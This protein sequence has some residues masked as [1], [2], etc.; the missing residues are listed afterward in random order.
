[1]TMDGSMHTLA[2]VKAEFSQFVESAQRT[3][4]RVVITKNGKPAA[5]LIGAEDYEALLETLEILSDPEMMAAI[6]EAQ[7][8]PEPAR[9]A[10]E[11]HAELRRA[12]QL[13]R[14]A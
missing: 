1:M 11:V 7:A 13:S 5:V 8:S 12:G 4:E 2:S 6:H 9:G 10:A 3:H 14:P